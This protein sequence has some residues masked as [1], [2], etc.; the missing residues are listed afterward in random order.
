MDVLLKQLDQSG[1]GLTISG[2]N[3]GCAAYADDIRAVSNGMKYL[4]CQAR[5]ILEFWESNAV[6]LNA[7]KTEVVTLSA[8]LLLT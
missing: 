1:L 5:L 7:S 3:A 8:L 4:Q 6:K 2:L